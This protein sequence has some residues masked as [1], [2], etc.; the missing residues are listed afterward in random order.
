MQCSFGNIHCTASFSHRFTRFT[1]IY[2]L[3]TIRQFRYFDLTADITPQTNDDER[4]NG[5]NACIGKSVNIDHMRLCHFMF[6]SG[7]VCAHNPTI[8]WRVDV[9]SSFCQ[10]SQYIITILAGKCMNILQSILLYSLA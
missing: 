4:Q 10:R 9:S 3:V 2:T 6:Y 7:N 5:F 1:L 8:Q